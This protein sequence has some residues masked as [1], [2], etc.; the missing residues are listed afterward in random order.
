[1]QLSVAEQETLSWPIYYAII[2]TT[3]EEPSTSASVRLISKV[4]N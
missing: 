4:K 1:M 3:K 2:K